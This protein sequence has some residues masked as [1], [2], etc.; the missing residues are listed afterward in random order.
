MAS[1]LYYMN[2]FVKVL[3]IFESNSFPRN[4]TASARTENIIEIKKGE[5]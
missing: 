3:N 5:N 1:A 4:W 2:K